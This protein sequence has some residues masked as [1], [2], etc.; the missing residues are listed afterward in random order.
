MIPWLSG[1]PAFPS[2]DRALREPNG[3]LAAG[4]ALST[5]WLLEAY[6]NGIFPWYSGGEPVLWW[7]PDPRLVLF[8]AEIRISR[9]LRK[10][11][12]SGRFEV[13]LDRA[14]ADVVA[15]C[16]EPRDEEGGTWITPPMRA[17]YTKLHRQGYAHSVECWHEGELAGGLYGVS[18]GKMFYG[19]SM[20]SR[21]SDASKV[22][23][24]HLARL[25]EKLGYGMID[26][27]MTTAHLLSMGARE[28]SRKTFSASLAALVDQPQAPGEWDLALIDNAAQWGLCN[29]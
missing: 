14:F 29:A 28:I 16:A 6:R 1:N 22:A 19:E 7:S 25:L 23:L 3:L 18:L 4:G 15:G 12:R 20:F 17:A 9:S 24:V 26:C 2:V 11:L 10:T 5:P 8:P 27:Q 13:T 21:V